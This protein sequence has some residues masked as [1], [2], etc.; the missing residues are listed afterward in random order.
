VYIRKIIV[1][2]FLLLSCNLSFAADYCVL[3]TGSGAKTG[4]D[5]NNAIDWT[6][7]SPTRGNTYWLGGGTYVPM[8]LSTTCTGQCSVIT[9]NKATAGGTAC[10]SSTPGWSDA[11]GTDQ[12]ILNS[13][14]PAGQ[15]A[16][17]FSS[18]YWV[19]DGITNGGAV[20]AGYGIKLTTST[21]AHTH[22]IIYAAINTHA[23]YIT[24]R[25]TWIKGYG[26][27]LYGCEIGVENEAVNPGNNNLVQSN[28][29][30]SLSNSI[31]WHSDTDDVV[32]GNYFLAVWGGGPA[33][34][35]QETITGAGTYRITIKNNIF[36]PG[37]VW[38]HDYSGG[39]GYN[40][41]WQI[42]NNLFIGLGAG[43]NADFVGCA[44]DGAGHPDIMRN[45][46]VHHNTIINWGQARVGA[47]CYMTTSAY[48]T[49]V[50]N[51]LFVN[52]TG[53]ILASG[54]N[55]NSI[56][57]DYNAF[58]NTASMPAE[59]HRNNSITADPFVSSIAP[60]DLHL[61]DATAG[62]NARVANPLATPFNVDRD[63]IAR[64]ATTPDAGAYEYGGSGGDPTLTVI[65]SGTGTGTVT[66]S[67]AGINCGSVCS[68]NYDGGT[69]VTLTATPDTGNSFAGWSGGG[70]AG[71]G[72][73]VVT[74]N[75]A[76]TVTATFTAPPPPSNYSL[77][78]LKSGA[79]TG[80]VSS[81]PSGID[82]GSTCSSDYTGGT[83]VTLTATPDSGMTFVG[84]SGAGCSGTGSCAVTMNAATTVTANF[85]TPAAPNHWRLSILK[86]HKVGTVAGNGTITSSPAGI[87][88]G[89]TCQADYTDGT[90]VTLTVTP[91]PGNSFTGWSGGGCSGAGTCVVNVNDDTSVTASF[92][93]NSSSGS[94]SGS[95]DGGGGGC[96]IATAAYGSYLDP[97]VY[98]LRN[99]RDR[100]LLTNSFG[101][102]FVNGYYRY[103]PPVA[104]FIGRHETLRV[105][106]RWALSP[107]V[108]C[109]EYPYTIVMVLPVG[110][111]VMYRRRKVKKLSE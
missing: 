9:I 6:A 107:V 53:V 68:A 89:T 42:Y 69:T 59:T 60:Y 14:D 94:S 98:V 39:A 26:S 11:Y 55:V 52:N 108:Y 77:T 10:N 78:T 96:F 80:Y 74:M 30:E 13:S 45:F 46:E 63:T 101:Q 50:Y 71:M 19:L 104:A 88:C 8:Q 43:Y 35:H 95:G 15:A 100:Y 106:A 92:T 38:I 58:Y 37:F 20:G 57:H 64:S 61:K 29:F 4:A 83:A 65:E 2:L 41:G 81:S 97:H 105:A 85:G 84:W 66:S 48:P 110:I 86:S 70:C 44:D 24:V 18:N 36:N 47:T 51:N 90:S 75:A 27:T 21:N 62:T 5:W 56:V 93:S 99:F 109:I 72:S 23:S 28:L 7:I 32:D 76:T 49:Y 33:A 111:M 17:I 12:A 87:D 34:C 54:E 67:P 82:C 40:T 22:D 31:V 102:A 73:C 25:N 103:S 1:A 79:G 3:P 91:D 16:I